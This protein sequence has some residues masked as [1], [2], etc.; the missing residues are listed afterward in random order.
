MEAAPQTV[1]VEV[2]VM[3]VAGMVWVPGWRVVTSGVGTTAAVGGGRT[4]VCLH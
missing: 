3:V 4:T 1:V 2:K